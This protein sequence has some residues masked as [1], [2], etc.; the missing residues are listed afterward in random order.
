MTERTGSSGDP[1]PDQDKPGEEAESVERRQV[2]EDELREIL[3]AHEK[4]LGS[5][6]KEGQ[7]ADLSRANL[8]GATL[9]DANL[10]G[11]ERS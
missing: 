9:W 4:W 7:P 8:Q 6:G 5:D 2:S 3:E 10:Q 1:G 11:G